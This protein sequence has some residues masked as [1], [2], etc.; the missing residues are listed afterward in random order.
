MLDLVMIKS[1]WTWWDDIKYYTSQ[2]GLLL[3]M[4]AVIIVIIALA[5]IWVLLIAIVLIGA[6][7]LLLFLI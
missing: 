4:A 6:W 1:K 2:T 7:K 5:L 3:A